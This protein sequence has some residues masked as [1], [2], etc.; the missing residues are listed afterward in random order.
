MKSMFFINVPYSFIFKIKF[1]ALKGFISFLPSKIIFLS[2]FGFSHKTST[3][4]KTIMESIWIYDEREN[5]TLIKFRNYHSRLA[6]FSEDN[7]DG[8]I[9]S[10]KIR[11]TQVGDINC[12]Q[13]FSR[14][15]WKDLLRPGLKRKNNINTCLTF[16]GPCIVIYS[17]NKSQQ[18]APF[19]NFIW[20]RP[21]HVSDRHRPSSGVLKLYSQQLVFAIL[22][23]LAVCWRGQDG[24][25]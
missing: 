3:D 23:M 4:T 24:T 18:D 16:I 10:I 8:L 15:I 1:Y 12:V 22:V 11:S 25:R 5:R 17:Y 20:W 21:L 9:K 2:N 14:K 19:Q 7:I 6:S 13:D